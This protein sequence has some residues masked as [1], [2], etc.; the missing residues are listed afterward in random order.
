[1][2]WCCGP[3]QNKKISRK[4]KR[5]RWGEDCSN[6]S[7]IYYKA[8][9]WSLNENW[10]HRWERFR[11]YFN[12][13]DDILQELNLNNIFRSSIFDYL[14]GDLVWLFKSI[15][16]LLT[17]IKKLYWSSTGLGLDSCYYLVVLLWLASGKGTRIYV[18]TPLGKVWL[19]VEPNFPELPCVIL[20]IS[21][22]YTP[23]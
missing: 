18:H 12:W 10:I 1:M 16:I 19:R 21:N 11:P 14:H 20:S 13:S 17:S 9:W 2:H 8:N 23:I 4:T 3:V 6:V 15:Y 7:E 22:L 5:R